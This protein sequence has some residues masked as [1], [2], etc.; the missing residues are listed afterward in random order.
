MTKKIKVGIL[1]ETKN[2]PDKRV[3]VTPLQVVKLTEQFSNVEVYVQPSDIRCYTDEEY[4]YLDLNMKEDLSDCDILLGVKE[5][6]PKTFIAD[7]TYMFFA[8]VAKK[9]PYNRGLLQEVIKKGIQLVDYE[10]LT[11]K[12]NQ[13]IV[14]FGRWA[15]IV[16]AYNGLRARGIR[17]DQF[18]L[19]PAHHCKDMDEMYAG[20]KKTKLKKKKI[21]VTGGGRVAMGAMETISQLN[22]REVTSDEFLN[23][24]FDEPV[25]CRIDPEH[26]VQH[27]GG[28]QFNLR[29][30]FKHPEEYKSAFKPYTKVTDIFIACHFWDPKSPN[31]I[32]KEDYLDP[33][34]KI[35]VIADVSCDVDGPIA[36]TVKASTI[37][38]PFFGY[39]PKTGKEEPPFINPKNVTVMSVD[40]LPGELPRNASSDF[41]SNLIDKVYPSLFGNDDNGIIERA[42]IAKGGKLTERYSYLKDYLEGKE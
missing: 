28:M 42:S 1:R 33:D 3:P 38:E 39:N 30:F 10:Y 23:Q 11:D 25:L 36:S 41:G 21:L 17:T 4:Q 8:H 26:Y 20:L 15:G 2:P 7:K 31:F 35:T 18:E 19:K 34:F 9:Q 29:H 27:K 37:A 5:V 24:E 16:G 14:A 12:D 22:I 40:N 6:D 32:T 13:R